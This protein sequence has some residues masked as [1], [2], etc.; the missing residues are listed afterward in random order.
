MRTVLVACLLLACGET[1]E[2]PSES[3]QGGADGVEPVSGGASG[4]GGEPGASGVPVAAGA[5][6]FGGAPMAGGAAGVGGISEAGASGAPMAGAG[7]QAGA[8]G[9]AGASSG[10]ESPSG[11][12]GGAQVMTGGSGGVV[13]T[14]GTGGCWSPSE[15]CRD[16]DADGFV[17]ADS[18]ERSCEQPSGLV[19]RSS[20]LGDDCYD[21]N[22]NARPNLEPVNTVGSPL[23][24]A[25]HRGDGSFDYDCDGAEELLYGLGE[26]LHPTLPGT[27]GW[28]D[29]I[30]DCGEHGTFIAIDD[31]GRCYEAQNIQACR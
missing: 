21:G 9:G 7:G 13:S 10:G 17:D 1:A 5:P 3:A 30:P 20:S 31:D 6:S 8:A 2:L 16:T 25:D 4:T 22:P 15:W 19:A 18:C 26:C 29:S 23:Y 12:A 14:G 27:I 11:G 24:F 28:A